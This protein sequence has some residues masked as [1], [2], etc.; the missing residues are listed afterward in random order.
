MIL[1]TYIDEYHLK[2]TWYL[3]E[4]NLNNL[5]VLLKRVVEDK[6]Y[7]RGTDQLELDMSY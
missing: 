7:L 4:V 6:N 3:R 5:D 2:K 1:L